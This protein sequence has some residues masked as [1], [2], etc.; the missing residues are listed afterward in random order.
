M[1]KSRSYAR[2]WNCGPLHVAP[3][4]YQPRSI[5]GAE[6]VAAGVEHAAAATSTATT[7]LPCI[8]DRVVDPV[9][10]EFERPVRLR[11]LENFRR[12]HQH[13]SSADFRFD[14]DDA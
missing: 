1:R 9:E 7:C 12:E 4:A 14:A 6:R 11:A 5:S 8:H 10:Q 13:F 3:P 2:T